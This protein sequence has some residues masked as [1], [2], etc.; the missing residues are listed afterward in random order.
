MYQN[1]Q[2]EVLEHRPV[3]CA[4]WNLIVCKMTGHESQATCILVEVLRIL[5]LRYSTTSEVALACSSWRTTP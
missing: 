2:W 5:C 3:D 1:M 4:N